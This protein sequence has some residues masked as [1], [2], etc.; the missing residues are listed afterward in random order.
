M[1]EMPDVFLDGLS[2][3]DAPLDFRFTVCGVDFN[4]AASRACVTPAASRSRAC[5]AGEGKRGSPSSS[6]S[7]A[8]K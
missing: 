8:S 3:R 2:G 1:D 4:A 6:A 5:S 7:T